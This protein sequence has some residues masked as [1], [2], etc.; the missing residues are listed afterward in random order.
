VDTLLDK[1]VKYGVLKAPYFPWNLYPPYN[2]DAM[3][4]LEGE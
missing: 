4:F 3:V 2:Y 1:K